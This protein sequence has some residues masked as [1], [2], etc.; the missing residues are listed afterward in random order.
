MADLIV[1]ADIIYPDIASAQ[2]ETYVEAA[3]AA[4]SLAEVFYEIFKSAI[5]QGLQE[6]DRAR[7]AQALGEWLKQP[8]NIG[9]MKDALKD[10]HTR[11]VRLQQYERATKLA[12]FVAASRSFTTPSKAF[13]QSKTVLTSAECKAVREEYDKSGPESEPRLKRTP[14]FERC[15]ATLLEVWSPDIQKLLAAAADYDSQADTQ[16]DHLTDEFL[17]KIDSLEKI[18][19]GTIDPTTTEGREVLDAYLQTAVRLEAWAQQILDTA[20]NGDNKKKIDDAIKKLKDSLK[21]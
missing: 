11:I 20:S 7:R 17:K 3:S 18:A 6:V 1:Y 9:R 13:E 4:I 14:L 8:Q 2:P 19:N 5:V 16:V 12:Q 10:A 21:T 15:F